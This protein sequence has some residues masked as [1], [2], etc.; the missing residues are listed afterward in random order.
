MTEAEAARY[1]A[2]ETLPAPEDLRGWVLPSL[3]GLPLGWGKASGGVVKNHV[4]K[5]LRRNLHLGDS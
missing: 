2:G 4:P 1:L 3:R 5:G